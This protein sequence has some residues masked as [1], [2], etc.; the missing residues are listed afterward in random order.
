MTYRAMTPQEKQKLIA[1][2][3]HAAFW[4]VVVFLVV[5]AWDSTTKN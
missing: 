3:K 5:L 1:A 2:L 4:A